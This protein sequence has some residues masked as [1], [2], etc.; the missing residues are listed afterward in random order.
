MQNG[1]MNGFLTFEAKES[2]LLVLGYGSITMRVS[3]IRLSTY[4]SNIG[5]EQIGNEKNGKLL[6]LT[7]MN[8][9]RVFTYSFTL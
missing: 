3:P 4:Y 7:S 8:L 5:K 9:R 2:Y 6:S 1:D